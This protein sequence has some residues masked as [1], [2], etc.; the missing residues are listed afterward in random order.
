MSKM[1][2]PEVEIELGDNLYLQ[3][4][5]V[6]FIPFKKGVTDRLPWDC[7]EDEPAECDWVKENAK[8]IVKEKKID[9][10][11]T[12]MMNYRKEGRPFKYK[13]IEHEFSVDD[14]FFYMYYDRIIEQIEEDL[15]NG[16]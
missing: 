12:E 16:N 10:T 11:Y 5:D 7:Y 4:K 2:I 15:S 9:M 6:S 13:T 8:L 14:S 1:I 3:I